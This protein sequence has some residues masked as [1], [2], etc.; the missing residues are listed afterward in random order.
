MSYEQFY[1]WRLV[2]SNEKQVGLEKATRLYVVLSFPFHFH[3]GQAT[4]AQHAG[5]LL[6]CYL[7]QDILLFCFKMNK[8]DDYQVFQWP[9]STSLI[10]LKTIIF[11]SLASATR[12]SLHTS[13]LLFFPFL[14]YTFLP[15]KAK[16]YSLA[17]L[18]HRCEKQEL[19]EKL[20]A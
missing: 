3:C 4:T 5:Q 6:C 15:S 14:F 9:I 2:R 12:K 18:S 17:L 16:T 11:L 1:T 20:A 13:F 10:N 7:F 19:A 8:M